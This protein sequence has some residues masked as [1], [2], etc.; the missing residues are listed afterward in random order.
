MSSATEFGKMLR[1]MR[2]KQSEKITAMAKK[3]GYSTSFLSA[4]E[5]GKKSVPPEMIK[6]L[7]EQYALNR[8]QVNELMQQ[9][10]ETLRS[11][12][13]NATEHNDEG[14]QTLFAFAR[15]LPELDD[16]GMRRLRENINGIFE[17]TKK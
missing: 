5:L 2:V 17:E 12:R 1:I 6:Q 13:I 4:V 9:A 8:E 11:V 3:L 14:K 10:S 7:E 15:V 16:E